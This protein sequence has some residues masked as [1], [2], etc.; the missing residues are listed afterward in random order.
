MSMFDLFRRF[1]HPPGMRD[2]F[3]G[4]MTQDD[5]DEEDDEGDGFFC[6]ESPS[7]R[8]QA[9]FRDPFGFED[10]FRDFNEMFADF[11]AMIPDAPRLPGVEPPAGGPGRSG[12]SLR[13]FMLKYPDSHLPRD[14]GPSTR[15]GP[16]QPG[17]LP[18]WGDDGGTVPPED[19]KQDKILDSEVSSRGLDSILRSKEPSPPSSSSYFRSVSVSRVMRPDG[20]VE[21]RRTAQD[22]EGNTTTTVTVTSSGASDP[23]GGALSDAKDSSL[24]PHRSLPDLSDSQTILS[25][26]LQR[27][28]S[29]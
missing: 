8:G 6:R 29:S 25:R 24:I 16:H 5:E 12:G 9:P 21:E 26:I 18:R 23:Y 3:F 28:F 7:W 22:S 11:G 14:Q 10:F 2:P 4:G 15:E 19:T 20:T 13:D 17:W 1:F 27:F